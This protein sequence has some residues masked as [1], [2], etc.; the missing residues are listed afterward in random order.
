MK[1]GR[2]RVATS[3]AAMM[4]AGCSL[5]PV[6]PGMSRDE[7]MASY[8]KPTR[9]VPLPAGTRLQY[10]RQPAGQSAVMVD[11]DASGKV[12]SVR[13]VLQPSG[14]A[15][16][17]VGQS[18]RDDVER[19][20]GPPAEISHVRSWTGDIM[21]Y[22]WRDSIHDMFFWVY[23]D[24]SQVAQRTGQGMEFRMEPSDAR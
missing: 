6:L 10:S 9:V 16:V 7:V 17:L 22:R 23:L 5:S 8:G 19:E 3:M 21:T 1:A 20:L 12:T 11:L 13:Q 14:F 4:L 15:R 2:W 24:P 18:T